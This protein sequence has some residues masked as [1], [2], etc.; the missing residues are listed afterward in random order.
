MNRL[1]EAQNALV[2][3]YLTLRRAIGIVGIALPFVV[4]L[5]AVIVFQTGL[6][7]SISGYYHTGM[8]DVFVGSL[9]VAGFF[10]LAYKGYGPIDDLAGN[11][12]CLFA[13][14][15]SLFPT[16]PAL[17]ASTSTWISVVHLVFGALF[18]LTLI[19]FSLY[20]FTK[21]DPR[22]QPTPE[23]LKR[24]LVYQICGYTM[25]VCL[26]LILVYFLL[27]KASAASL[28]TLNPVFWLETVALLAFG[29]SWLTK[30]EALLKD[31]GAARGE[32]AQ[33][34]PSVP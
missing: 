27:P 20:L 4:A 23:K 8:R 29:V 18:F 33:R 32:P 17:P 34:A 19:F 9:W 28:K 3:S 13:V 25:A 24:N 30:G 12:G 1:L 21:T 16:A 15:I 22:G 11:F 7:G 31:Q 14:G 10:L 6:Q 2:F 5:G 26:L